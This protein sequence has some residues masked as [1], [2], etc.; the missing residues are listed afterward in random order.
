MAGTPT[1]NRDTDL[2]IRR[3][4][5]RF[6]TESIEHGWFGNALTVKVLLVII[7]EYFSVY[8]TYGLASPLYR[9]CLTQST[10]ALSLCVTG[11]QASRGRQIQLQ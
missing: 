5:D 6:A 4:P 2:M 3:N 7:G 9:A 8:S 10:S 11:M 1:L